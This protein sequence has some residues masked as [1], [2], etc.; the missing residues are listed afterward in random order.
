MKIR[1]QTKQV[2]MR[3]NTDAGGDQTKM[4]MEEKP[5]MEQL[6]KTTPKHFDK[7]SQIQ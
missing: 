1:D 2:G 6:V 3:P 5:I 4:R 7:A